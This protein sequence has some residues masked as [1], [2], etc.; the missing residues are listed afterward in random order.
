MTPHFSPT[1]WQTLAYDKPNSRWQ[2]AQVLLCK[3]LP[4]PERL[5]HA[6]E[7]FFSGSPNPEML[8]SHHMCQKCVHVTLTHRQQACPAFSGSKSVNGRTGTG[9]FSTNL[10]TYEHLSVKNSALAAASGTC[11]VLPFTRNLDGRPGCYTSCLGHELWITERS[12]DR[13]AAPNT[14]R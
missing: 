5:F 1:P 4:Q 2:P 14:M 7:V 6:T 12:G 11:A 8:C 3:G 9:H 13:S 10:Q